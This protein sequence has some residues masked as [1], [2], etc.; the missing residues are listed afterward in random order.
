MEKAIEKAE[1]LKAI[2]NMKLNLTIDAGGAYK[3]G[4]PS[5]TY[6]AF[7]KD[8][9]MAE[10]SAGEKTTRWYYQMAAIG[11][12]FLHAWDHIRGNTFPGYIGKVSTDEV[13]GTIM[14][15]VILD[16][17]GLSLPK[18]EYGK[19]EIPVNETVK[20]YFFEFKRQLTSTP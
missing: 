20:K 7:G 1:G 16:E 6:I 12:E 17:W 11:H 3:Y 8:V 9:M 2:D 5:D 15:Q 14:E 18:F 4:K 19:V 13:R 10:L